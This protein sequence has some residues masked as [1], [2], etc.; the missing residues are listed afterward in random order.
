[1]SAAEIRLATGERARHLP[2][3]DSTNGEAF[4]LAAAG[5]KGPLWLWADI[6]LQGRGRQG[7]RWESEP[8]NLYATLLLS[9]D[10]WPARAASLS[11]AAPLAV[12]ATLNDF[13][14][15][16]TRARLKWPNDVLVDNRKVAGILVESSTTADKRHVFAVGCGLNLH[17][18]PLRSR[19]GATSLF[20][21]G[22]NVAPL[23]ALE[24][25]ARQM[26]SAIST[27]NGGLGIAEIRN[28]WLKHADGL[29][30]R[31]V[32]MR[33][34]D[35]LSGTFEGLAHSGALQLRLSDGQLAEIHAGEVLSV[36][37]T[38]ETAV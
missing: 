12:V 34:D 9:F 31:I 6:Q 23:M 16:S 8:G 33:G 19:Y 30:Q 25:L 10:E 20:D 38:G 11:L 1:M 32:V 37:V 36:D 3:V 26:R 28:A 4:R 22:V 14:P 24:A 5:E 17:Q 21:H 27:W 29:G 13:L 2:T 15:G 35:A 18:A 7:R